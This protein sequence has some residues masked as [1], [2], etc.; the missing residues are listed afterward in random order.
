MRPD[1]R[2]P[3]GRRGHRP[4][5]N[6]ARKLFR[7]SEQRG[8]GRPTLSVFTNSFGDTTCID[9]EHCRN[10][11][12]TVTLTPQERG[13]GDL[14]RLKRLAMHFDAVQDHPCDGV[15]IRSHGLVSIMA[16]GALGAGNTLGPCGAAIGE[17]LAASLRA[18]DV[19]LSAHTNDLC[20]DFASGKPA[21]PTLWGLGCRAFN[22]LWQPLRVRG[23]YHSES[24]QFFA[25]VALAHNCS[26]LMH[27]RV[28]C[29]AFSYIESRIKSIHARATDRE[30]IFQM[31]AQ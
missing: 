18:D 29:R 14:V 22:L 3:I 2:P 4:R 16:A 12:H 27:G 25:F 11:V 30:F 15:S 23:R 6:L 21:H 31:C 26:G 8:L 13:S 28:S 7:T 1:A 17:K 20:T 9:A 5:A 10:I 19:K 24:S